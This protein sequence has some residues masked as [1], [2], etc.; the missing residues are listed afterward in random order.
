MCVC[1]INSSY[2]GI[3]LPVY[4]PKGLLIKF[5]NSFLFENVF[6]FN[7]REL[8]FSLFGLCGHNYDFFWKNT[9]VEKSEASCIP[10][11]SPFLHGW[12]HSL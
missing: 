1:L 11:Q 6:S 2:C 10:L 7:I 3:S 8:Y 4:F 5:L 12:S 9:S